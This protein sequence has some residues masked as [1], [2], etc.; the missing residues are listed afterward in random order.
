MNSLIICTRREGLPLQGDDLPVIAVSEKHIG[1]CR[2]CMR[3]KYV[4]KCIAYQDDAQECL[5]LIQEAAHLDIYLQSGSQTRLLFDR[6]LYALEGEGRTFT[7]HVE[8]DAEAEY[9]K[10]LLTWVGYKEV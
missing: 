3:C 4:K 6:T 8:D 7:L 10:N 1:K 5:P 9:L 2:G